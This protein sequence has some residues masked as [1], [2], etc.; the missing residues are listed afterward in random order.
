MQV[1]GMIVN[2][3][4]L[5]F[6]KSK[7]EQASE[8]IKELEGILISKDTL[9]GEKDMEIQRLSLEEINYKRRIDVLEVKYTDITKELAEMREANKK[10][11]E[12]MVAILKEIREER[13]TSY[14]QMLTSAISTMA[15][16]ATMIMGV[17][18]SLPMLRDAINTVRGAS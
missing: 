17:R 14:Y 6:E 15:C 11:Q 16:V 2:E 10:T 13:T 3:G 5:L 18:V 7:L 1:R 4:S 9:I 12:D 8:R